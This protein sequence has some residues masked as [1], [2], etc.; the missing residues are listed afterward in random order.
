METTD[1]YVDTHNPKRL[2]ET[3]NR[4]GAALIQE[5]SQDYRR[6]NGHYIV[7]CF[8]DPNFIKFMITNQGYGTV[9]DEQD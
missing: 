3:L 5:N 4:F 6:V 9:I 2:D 8:S 1:F 7:R